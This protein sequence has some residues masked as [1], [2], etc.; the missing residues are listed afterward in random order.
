MTTDRINERKTSGPVMF[1]RH[2]WSRDLRFVIDYGLGTK[3]M[4]YFY[5]GEWKDV[6]VLLIDTTYP[7][8][9]VMKYDPLQP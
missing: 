9:M 4:Q 7:P 6:P 8:K 3:H 5:D 1:E 2:Y